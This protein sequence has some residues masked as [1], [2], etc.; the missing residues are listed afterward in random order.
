MFKVSYMIR[1]LIGTLSYSQ[2]WCEFKYYHWF[3]IHNFIIIST[4][5]S[6]VIRHNLDCEKLLTGLNHYNQFSYI[7]VAKIVLA[8]ITI[9]LNLKLHSL[10]QSIA[11]HLRSI[12]MT[13][14][15]G[16]KNSV[17]QDQLHCW[18]VP[19]W[20]QDYHDY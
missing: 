5:H 7:Y 13:S 19:I 2:F 20:I 1:T 18:H 17:H 9:Y 8:I 12:E 3:Y 14:Y 15:S 11:A 10:R 16:F 4:P 6:I